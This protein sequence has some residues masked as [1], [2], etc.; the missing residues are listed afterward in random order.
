M[1][2]DEKELIKAFII[3]R[4]KGEI[5]YFALDILNSKFEIDRLVDYAREKQQNNALGYLCEVIMEALP[6]KYR[7]SKQVIG[8]L[9]TKLYSHS[10]EWV[11]LSKSLPDFGK[12]ILAKSNQTP[13]NEKWHVYSNLNS[14]EMSDWFDIYLRLQNVCPILKEEQF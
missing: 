14:K 13:R 1:S 7:Q 5:K 3:S 6:K 11:Y 8:N 10:D 12:R 4:E 9:V 2:M